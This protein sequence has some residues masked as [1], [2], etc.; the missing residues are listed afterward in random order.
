MIFNYN[1]MMQKYKTEYKINKAIEKQEIFKIERGIYSD[2]ENVNPTEVIV[3]KYPNAIFSNDT[4]YYMHDLTDVIPRKLDLSTKRHSLKINDVN[5]NQFFVSEK[6]F[7]IGKIQMEYEGVLVNI[8]DKERMLIEL[9]RNQ[10]SMPLDY[11]KE[12]LVSYRKIADKLEAWKLDEYASKF[13]KLQ[14]FIFNK[15]I[16]EVF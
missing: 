16:K 1:E 3:K 8:Y 5:I 2:K 4:A 14:S 12:I 11:Y 15:L 9:I 6:F 13:P 10:K 7:E